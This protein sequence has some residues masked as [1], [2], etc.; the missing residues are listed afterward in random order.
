M[1]WKFAAQLQTLYYSFTNEWMIE[2][3]RKCM[4]MNA[5]SALELLTFFQ[6]LANSVELIWEYMK[7][8]I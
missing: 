2:N 6:Y 7:Q 1:K 5:Y 8:Q 4:E 3:E